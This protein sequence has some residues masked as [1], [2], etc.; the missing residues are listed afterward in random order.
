MVNGEYNLVCAGHGI[1]RIKLESNWFVPRHRPEPTRLFRDMA[2]NSAIPQSPPWFNHL[3]WTKITTWMLSKT[4]AQRV[5]RQNGDWINRQEGHTRCTLSWCLFCAAQHRIQMSFQSGQFC[6]VNRSHTRSVLFLLPLSAL[7]SWSKAAQLYL[8]QSECPCSV[9]RVWPV[10][11]STEHKQKT[12][13]Y[14]KGKEWR[15]WWKASTCWQT[16]VVYFSPRAATLNDN[17]RAVGR[18]TK[19]SWEVLNILVVFP[20]E[21]VGRGISG[22]GTNSSWGGENLVGRDLHDGETTSWRVENLLLFQKLWNAW[23]PWLC[24]IEKS[25]LFVI[26][27]YNGVNVAKHSELQKEKAVLDLPGSRFVIVHEGHGR[28][29][30]QQD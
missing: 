26:K 17:H 2:T 9:D 8:I 10:D 25:Y 13:A 3:F 19:W 29:T 7:P 4:S 20:F 1:T 23:R 24:S 12:Y 22:G 15:V 6:P 28:H 14:E 27:C 16:A 5:C 30:H 21:L 18:R 11:E